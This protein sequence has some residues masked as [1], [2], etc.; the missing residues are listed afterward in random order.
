MS[1][2]KKPKRADLR[3]DLP[4]KLAPLMQP[5]RYKIAYGGRG[6]G[7]SHGF[8]QALLVQ[9]LQDPLRILCA[10]E[11]QRTIGDSVH[12]LLVDQIAK[13][14]LE[15]YFT[16][17]E[18]SIKSI[19]GA[20]FL[21]SG[22]RQQDAHKIKS[23]EGCD[24]AW[25]EEAQAVTKRSWDI[26]IPTIRAERSE[27][28]CSF[29]PELDNDDTYQRFVV[30]PPDGAVVMRMTWRDNPWFPAVLEAER[31]SLQKRDPVEYEHVWEGK[32]RTVVEGAIYAREVT[33]MIVTRRIRPVPYDPRLLVH[34]I[35]DLGWNDQT[36]IIFVQRLLSEIRVIDYEEESFLRFDEWAKKIKDKPYLYGS[37]WLPHDGG[38]ATQAAN[39]VSAQKLLTPL[40]R[41]KPRLIS[42]P[43]TKEVP[44]RA[45]RMM[46]PRA[47]VDET[48]CVRLLDCLKRFRR[49]VPQTTGEPGNPV[50]DEYSH[51]ADAWGGLAMIVDKLTNDEERPMLKTSDWKPM[52]SRFF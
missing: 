32:P 7:K 38:H 47:Y 6:A 15:A 49:A 42:R 19:Y 12:R 40:L 3:V 17:T 45:A 27:I 24:V 5:H 14:G 9:A 21:F 25:I 48:A 43:E 4:P 20:E 26:L 11:I 28:W 39:G 29:N 51:G 33:E 50:H 36:S 44:I 23:F 41:M 1:T 10:R 18:S 34:T 16:V 22:L 8:A 2:L 31:L 13:I 35:W 52:D 37:H 30:N 46:F